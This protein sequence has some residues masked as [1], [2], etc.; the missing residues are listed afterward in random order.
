MALPSNPNQGSGLPQRPNLPQRPVTPPNNNNGALPDVP[1]RSSLGQGASELAKV[2]RETSSALPPTGDLTTNDRLS[3]YDFGAQKV[4]SPSRNTYDDEDP[5][6]SIAPSQAILD[7]E[8]PI[9]QSQASAP[10]REDAQERTPRQQQAA[11]EFEKTQKVR[12]RKV[13]EV[14]PQSGKLDKKGQNT[15]IDEDKKKLKPFGGKKSLKA[16][17]LDPRKN[18]RQ[19][20]MVV[21]TVAIV[22]LVA[23]VGFGAYNAIVPRPTLTTGDVVKTIQ[24]TVSMTNFPLQQGEGFAKDFM[25]SYLEL[26]S[27]PTAQA[28][29]N[30]Y[31]SGRMVSG[32][33]NYP[34]RYNSKGYAQ[35]ILYGP[36][37]YGSQYLTDQSGNYTIGAL[38]QPE[39]VNTANKVD[40][41]ATPTPEPTSSTA[42]SSVP[43]G[44]TAVW[45]F[46]SV[47]VYYDSATLQFAITP[48]SPTLIPKSQNLASSNAPKQADIGTGKLIDKQES[49][50]ATVQGFME[51]YRTSTPSDHIR[52]DQY[53]KAK[54]I[55]ELLNGLGSAYTFA[56][57]GVDGAVT[58]MAYATDTSEVKVLVKVVWE[59][60]Y[61]TDVT[62]TY[63][64]QYIMTLEPSSNGFAVTKFA[65][66]Y[67]TPKLK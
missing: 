59:Y 5:F 34:N 51:G 63:N 10:D 15:F 4:T 16:S 14:K 43:D 40:P 65:P 2:I 64:S 49:V 25:K 13:K 20:A 12:G 8:E 39:N 38:V 9:F 52:L 45:Q 28:V 62:S 31:Y 44:S 33:E 7:D 55:P 17:D 35:T 48:D 67:Y 3:Q 58:Y 11:Q 61:T 47:N 46:F 37:V 30:Y 6:E 42:P 27:N 60:D 29:L 23:I 21:Q 24:Q 56:N 50:K 19:Q 54:P 53:L 41:N 26:G 1:P 36:T 18:I 66:Y 57:K 22:L 32:S